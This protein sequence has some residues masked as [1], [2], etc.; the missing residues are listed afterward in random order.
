MLLPV[1]RHHALQAELLS[2][3]IGNRRANQAAPVRS[4]EVN[5]LRG[6]F[7]GGHYQVAFVLTIGIIRHNDDATLGDIAYHIVNSVKLKCLLR[8]G[9]H[10]NN[11]I[12]SSAVL[13]NSYSSARLKH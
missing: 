3:F 4:H 10:R 13:S 6:Y 5:R 9:D 1:P 2:T 8:L 7:F 11:T 12:T